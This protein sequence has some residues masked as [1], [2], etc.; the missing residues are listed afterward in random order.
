MEADNEFFEEVCEAGGLAA[1]RP[2]G[3]KL[4]VMSLRKREECGICGKEYGKSNKSRHMKRH[5]DVD[6]AL[7][8]HVKHH[9]SKE[10]RIGKRWECERCK[11]VFFIRGNYKVHVQ[12]CC[13]VMGL[14]IESLARCVEKHLRIMILSDFTLGRFVCGVCGKCFSRR[15]NLDRHVEASK[16]EE[17]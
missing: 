15:S 5:N 7:S 2:G 8:C 9:K 1:Q 17:S 16:H 11:K 13:T 4:A 10:H 3:V 12:K 14:G 6:K